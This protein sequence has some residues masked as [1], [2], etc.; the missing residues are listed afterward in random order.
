MAKNRV[1]FRVMT[2]F[3]AGFSRWAYFEKVLGDFSGFF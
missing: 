2:L 1:G 3:R